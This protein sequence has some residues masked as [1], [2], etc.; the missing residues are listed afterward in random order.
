MM[1]GMMNG[2]DKKKGIAALILGK[3]KSEDVPEVESDNSVGLR[4]AAEEL[5]AAVHSKDASGV[6]SAL[7]SFFAM[8]EE[9]EESE[10]KQE[11][12]YEGGTEKNV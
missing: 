3:P 4:A 5:I 1:P 7:K 9:S 2:P 11:E 6:M 8:S 10:D 12:E